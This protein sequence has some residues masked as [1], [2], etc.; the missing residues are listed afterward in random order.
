MK[1]GDPYSKLLVPTFIPN[2]ISSILCALIMIMISIKVRRP[3]FLSNSRIGKPQP[4][5]ISRFC[6]VYTSSV[7]LSPVG[8]AL[9]VR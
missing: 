9:T 7:L 8:F 6:K 3:S 4:T 1:P 5:D 2:E